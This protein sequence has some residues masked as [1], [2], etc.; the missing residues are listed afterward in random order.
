[1]IINE[2]KSKLLKHKLERLELT[3]I[4]SIIPY[5]VEEL[6]DGTRY[7]GYY[8]KPNGYKIA[9]WQWLLKKF[10]KKIS[11][12]QWRW[13]SSGGRLILAKSVLQNMGVLWFSLCR[14][15]K[16]MSSIHQLI[17][18]F[19][20]SGNGKQ[21]IH[22]VGWNKL[23]CPYT[24]GGW[25]IK[26]IFHFSKDL[27]AKSLWHATVD[28]L[29][30]RILKDKYFDWLAWAP[31]NGHHILIGEDPIVGSPI[32]SIA[33]IIISDAKAIIISIISWPIIIQLILFTIG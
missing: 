33:L 8:L 25:A 18:R 10:D 20:W 12:W 11:H 5:K 2:I 23:T 7:L 28:C 1:M 15:P 17:H 9:D 3:A 31:G 24:H 22:L 27:L 6:I 29:W 30:G 32:I 16:S 4:S 13:L 21:K 26:N 14:I 19:I